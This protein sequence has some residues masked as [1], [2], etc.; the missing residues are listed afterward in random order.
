M[1]QKRYSVSMIN[2][3]R[4]GRKYEPVQLRHFHPNP[5]Q[6]T[7]WK[8]KEKK[9]QYYFSRRTNNRHRGKRK[10]RRP[11]LSADNIVSHLFL[12]NVNSIFP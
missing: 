12:D 4:P 1:V 6:M 2:I 3:R 10:W 7:T 11:Q 9:S 5:K 8:K